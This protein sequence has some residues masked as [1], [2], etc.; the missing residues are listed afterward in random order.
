VWCCF[1]CVGGFFS[2]PA[3]VPVPKGRGGGGGEGGGG[4]GHATKMQRA[5]SYLFASAND[6]DFALCVV[7][8]GCWQL[9]Y[10]RDIW[11]FAVLSLG[12][13]ARINTILCATT[14]C[15]G[16][17]PHPPTPRRRHRPNENDCAQYNVCPRPPV[18]RYYYYY[19]MTIYIIYIY[20]PHPH[21]NIGIGNGNIV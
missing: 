14:L 5:T 18:F 20:I 10:T 1:V 11:R 8:A 6:F 17:L 16:T 21:S 4:G 12:S 19:I 3:G 13:C 2:L 15:L 7:S 9:A